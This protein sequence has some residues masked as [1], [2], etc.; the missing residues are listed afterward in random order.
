[1]SG[2][3]SGQAAIRVVADAAK[4]AW[5]NRSLINTHYLAEQVRTYIAQYNAQDTGLRLLSFMSRPCL[6]AAAR[7]GKQRL[8]SNEQEFLICYAI[9]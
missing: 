6:E 2:S 5:N 9:I 3:N 1:M 7:L 4:A 8:R